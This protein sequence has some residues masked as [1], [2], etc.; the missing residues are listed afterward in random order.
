MAN[1]PPGGM[2]YD[3]CIIVN[4]TIIA[5]GKLTIWATRRAQLTIAW[6]QMHIPP[7]CNTTVPHP[8]SCQHV[9]KAVSLKRVAKAGQPQ[10]RSAR[11][12]LGA[13]QG[14]RGPIGVD[15]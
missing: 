14:R 4:T 5:S 13:D 6:G 2:P 15:S 1:P 9:A 3:H 7:P 11:R 10:S 12:L 8:I